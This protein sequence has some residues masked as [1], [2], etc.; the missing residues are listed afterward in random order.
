MQ[1]PSVAVHINSSS[2]IPLSAK[3][4]MKRWKNTTFLKFSV[5]LS[6]GKENKPR[7][8]PNLEKLL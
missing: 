6:K 7:K 2:A 8:I 1:N 5:D 3:K 4:Q